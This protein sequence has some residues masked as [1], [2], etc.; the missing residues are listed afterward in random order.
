MAEFVKVLIVAGDSNEAK[1]TSAV[2]KHILISMVVSC[3]IL[4]KIIDILYCKNSC[5]F[6]PIVKS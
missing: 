1:V 3:A 2:K 5:S 6:L 4:S